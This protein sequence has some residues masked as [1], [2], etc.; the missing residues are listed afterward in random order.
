[1]GKIRRQYTKE[2]REQAVEFWSS[3]G[4]NPPQVAVDV[5]ISNGLSRR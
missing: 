4:K 1:M 3:S 5:E 2:R